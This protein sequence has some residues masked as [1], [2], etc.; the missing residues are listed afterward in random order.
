[1]LRYPDVSQRQIVFVYANDLWLVDRAGGLATPLASPAGA[2]RKPRFSV[3][4]QSI[5][6]SGNYEGDSDLYTM[7]VNGGIPLWGDSPARYRA[8]LRLDG[9]WELDL[10]DFI[11]HRTAP[12]STDVYRASH[13][14][15][16]HEATHSPRR[17]RHDSR[18]WKGLGLCAEQPGPSQLEAL[19]GGHGHGRVALRSASQDLAPRNDLGGYGQLSH[20]AWR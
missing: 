10:L 13:G 20:V 3:D 7:S 17:Q 8:N 12:S 4:G 18:R 2:E 1:M 5:A 19:Q 14:W 9:G 16:P 6:F 15:A 11:L